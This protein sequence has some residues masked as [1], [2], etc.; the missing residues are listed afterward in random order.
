MR[1]FALWSFGGLAILATLGPLLLPALPVSA[2]G[3]AALAYLCGA[4]V[5]GDFLRRTYPHPSL[6]L[7]NVVTLARLVIVMG[8][9]AS[10]FAGGTAA[11]A[12]VALAATALVL[13]GVDGWL[14]RRNGLASRFGARFDMETDAA[15]AFVLACHALATGTT[16]PAVLVLG[17]MRYA[18]VAASYVL[19]WLDGPL[20]E[21]ISRKA[22][23]VLQIATLIVIQIPGLP[24]APAAALVAVAS[25]ALVWSFAVDIVHLGRGRP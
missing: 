4:L 13:D 9:A 19:P 7:C 2:W 15:L 14:A 22:I 17:V 5:T 1:E 25:A 10:L 18:F 21:R 16:G 12:V 11:W 3:L 6:G 24:A 8:L 20:P 23:C